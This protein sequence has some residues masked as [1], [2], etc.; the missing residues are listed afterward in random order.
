MKA[1]DYCGHC[2]RSEHGI[3]GKTHKAQ[4]TFSI[5]EVR[6][7]ASS[8]RRQNRLLQTL[9]RR[10]C[11]DFLFNPA[12]FT[13]RI[14]LAS[15]SWKRVQNQNLIYFPRSGT[16][17]ITHNISWTWLLILIKNVVFQ[18]NQNPPKPFSSGET[19]SADGSSRTMKRSGAAGPQQTA[20][21]GQ[22]P[23]DVPAHLAT[24]TRHP[25]LC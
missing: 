9:N 17:I 4:M 8:S 12:I 14:I 2:Y 23:K 3:P 10:Y 1:E 22:R 16:E 13:I 11:D 24:E 20:K 21:R 25:H 7:S 18:N 15:P 19:E 5:S 6:I